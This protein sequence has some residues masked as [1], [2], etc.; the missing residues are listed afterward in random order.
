M[1]CLLMDFFQIVISVVFCCN[2]LISNL[3]TLKTN[4]MSSKILQ[5]S[6][7]FCDFPQKTLSWHKKE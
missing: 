1:S 4:L 7:N 3:L 5:I 6:Y 2:Y